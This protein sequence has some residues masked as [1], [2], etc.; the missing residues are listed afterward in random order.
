ML[1]S[2]NICGYV[3]RFVHIEA[4]IDE[5]RVECEY[6]PFQVHVTYVRLSVCDRSRFQLELVCDSCVRIN[7]IEAFE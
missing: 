5:F 3:V 6:V 7:V 1:P 2:G 4:P